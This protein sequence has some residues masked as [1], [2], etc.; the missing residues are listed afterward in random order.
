MG[1]DVISY[2]KAEKVAALAMSG[3]DH[4]E[5][6]GYTLVIYPVTGDPLELEFPVPEDGYSPTVKENPFNSTN[7]YKLDITYK[8]AQGDIVSYTTP[9]LKGQGGS[10]GGGSAELSDDLDVTQNV[11]GITAGKSYEEGTPLE[12][13]FRDM[14]NPVLYPT[15]TAPNVS[16]SATGAKLL[17]IGAVLSTTVTATFSRGTINPSYGT[18]GYRSGAATGYILN[19]GE[20]QSSNVFSGVII[21]EDNT[22]LQVVTNYAAGEQPKDSIGRD[23]GTPLAAGSVTS[24]TI[25]YEFVNALWANT[26]N[27]AAISKL[28]LV[29][30]TAKVKT[31]VFPAATVANPEVFDVPASWT[32]TALEVLNT[33]SNQWENCS[34]EF[35]VTDT[36]HNDASGQETAYKRYTN[37]LGYA[38]GS[39]SIRIKWN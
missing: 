39:R 28:A 7:V 29:S 27:I 34:S 4:F 31:F 33:L 18:S 19:G 5:I 30:K 8:N 20:E 35:T 32:I 26:D 1:L 11:G 21:S 13:I 15:L 10:G 16:I 9:N 2:T 36:V 25:N 38:M 14:L 6:D 22:S 37:N 3:V 12:D 24:N 17:E 23:Y